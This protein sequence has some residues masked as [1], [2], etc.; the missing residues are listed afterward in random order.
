MP[1]SSR[2]ACRRLQRTDYVVNNYTELVAAGITLEDVM[3]FAY[4]VNEA[5]SFRLNDIVNVIAQ[6]GSFEA[7]LR[8]IRLAP[9]FI[10]FRILNEWRPTLQDS[11]SGRFELGWAGPKGK[12]F[13][14]EV[15]T[16]KKLAEGLEKPAAIAELARLDAAREA[17]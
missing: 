8:V 11:G 6:D 10:E 14:R 16:G 12:W 4:W 7:R 3:S 9:G 5:G 15:A 13:V 2:N 1:V 17:A